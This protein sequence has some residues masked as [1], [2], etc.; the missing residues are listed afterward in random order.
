MREA[1]R[2]TIALGMTVLPILVGVLLLLN[3]LNPLFQDR[4]ARWFSGNFLIDPLIGA[5]AG[6]LSY[7]IPITSYITGGELLARGVSLVAVTAF[8][9]TWTT[10]GLVMVPLE[11]SFLGKKFALVRNLSNFLLAIIMAVLTVISLDYLP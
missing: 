4:Y 11:A 5:M 3:L 2:K 10:V 8:I 6:S 1:L 7:G 9:M